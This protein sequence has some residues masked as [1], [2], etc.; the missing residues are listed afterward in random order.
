MCLFHVRAL[1]ARNNGDAQVHALDHRNEALRNR[2]A[3][4]DAAEDIDED[5]RHFG[6]ARDERKGLLDGL[7]CGSTADICKL[8][9]KEKKKKK[10][11]K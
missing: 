2:V 4:H 10:V 8:S 9:K 7:R 6:V 3:P 11:R 5:G 1:Q